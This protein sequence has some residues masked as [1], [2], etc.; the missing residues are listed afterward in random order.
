MMTRIKVG[1]FSQLATIALTIIAGGSLL[2]ATALVI[3]NSASSSPYYSTF[4]YQCPLGIGTTPQAVSLGS[5]CWDTYTIKSW[6]KSKCVPIG[7]KSLT[8][9]K[10]C[11]PSSAQMRVNANKIVYPCQE[12]GDKGKD[13]FTKGSVKIGITES[14]DQCISVDTWT[15]EDP[16]PWLQELYCTARDGLANWELKQCD[17]GCQDGACRPAALPTPIGFGKNTIGGNNGKIYHVTNL[18]DSGLGSLRA[19]AESND[20]LWIVFDV[21]GTVK[22]NGE[23]FVHSNKT[24][25]GRGRKI[26]INKTMRLYTQPDYGY[27]VQNVIVENIIFENSGTADAITIKYKAKNIWIDHCTFYDGSGG[28]PDG[29]VDISRASTDIT[30]SWSQFYNHDKT[31]LIGHADGNT[32]DVD[33][34]VTLHH[35][36]FNGTSERHPRLRYGKVHAFNN[37]LFDWHLRSSPKDPK[38]FGMVSAENGQLYSESNIF[39]AGKNKNA[40]VTSGDDLGK[41]SSG[42]AKSVGDLFLNGAKA[43]LRGQDKVF[44]PS[45]YYAYTADKANNALK[46]LLQSK[47]G[48]QQQ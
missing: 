4:T 19:G 14:T 2:A 45:D 9:G 3:N 43:Q 21:S 16:S 10:A 29:L 34:R 20:P 42:N 1:V 5:N 13:Y 32:E 17:N 38:T 48:W 18:K 24:I 40:I 33:I 26:L 35:N 25:D 6:S 47:T 7:Y 8:Y 31:M 27:A 28:E 36:F 44:N 37:Y 30:I 41:S 46:I 15:V 39:E 12:I 23:L 11:S 22:L